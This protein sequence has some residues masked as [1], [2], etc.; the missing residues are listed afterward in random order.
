MSETLLRFVHITDT[1]ISADPHY[2]QYG[3][4]HTP[5]VGA[6]A[7]VHQINTLPFRPDFV[8]H[9]GDVAYNPD[10]TAYPVAKEI[11]SEIEVPVY[12]LAGNHDDSAAL[13]RIMLG[14]SEAEIK[15]PFD[16]EFEVNGVQIVAL[17]SNRKANNWCGRVS[18][19]QLAWLE[20]RT[21]ANDERPMIVTLHHNVLPMGSIW[22]DE[23]MRLENGEDFHKAL[24]PARER[25]RGVFSGHVHQN[26]DIIRD[27]I[28]Y[29]TA[30]SSWSQINNYPDQTETE[31][32]RFSNP[33]Y[34]IVTVT[35][36]QIYVRRCTFIVEPIRTS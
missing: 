7:L 18:A 4:M 21:S 16:Y 13:Q 26:T 1:H 27:G 3:A 9:T 30:K 15:T 5:M 25:I 34:S 10:E 22:W 12:Y 29:F 32:D 11:L 36:D 24:L 17:D 28:A 23:W 20:S 2:N 19:E 6:T 14:T 35:R 33:G 31:I 8:L